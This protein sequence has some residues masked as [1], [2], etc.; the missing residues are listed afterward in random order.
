[1]PNLAP[2]ATSGLVTMG[3]C[4]HVGMGNCAAVTQPL[5]GDAFAHLTRANAVNWLPTGEVFSLPPMESNVLTVVLLPLALF[6]IMLGM[7]LGLTLDDFKRI[8]T[9]T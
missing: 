5:Q 2:I 7:G 1:M 4:R 9:E 8:L 3:L 6:I